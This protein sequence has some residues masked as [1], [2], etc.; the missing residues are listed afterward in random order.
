[1]SDQLVA[2]LV[3]AGVSSVISAVVSLLVVHLT[4]QGEEK[5]ALNN[6]L[7]DILKIGI[8]YPYFEMETFASTWHPEKANKDERYAKYELY[9]TL[10]FNHLERR[11][12]FHAPALD[13]RQLDKGLSCPRLL[14]A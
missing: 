8:E 5:R 13:R 4:R 9:A 6:E 11:C 10:V 2:A 7:S 3:A 1:M 14:L 12:K